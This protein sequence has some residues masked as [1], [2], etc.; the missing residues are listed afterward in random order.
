MMFV[1]VCFICSVLF[2][3]WCMSSLLTKTGHGLVL[4]EGFAAPSDHLGRRLMATVGDNETEFEK[5][6]TEPDVQSHIA[7]T[8]FDIR[9]RAAEVKTSLLPSSVFLGE[10]VS[11]DEQTSYMCL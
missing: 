11:G 8:L 7:C 3:A 6:C 1:Q 9:Q 10:E 5:N 2:M 4:Q